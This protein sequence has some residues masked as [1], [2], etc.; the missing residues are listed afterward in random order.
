M[1]DDGGAE[2]G[3]AG[4]RLLE[5][6][7]NL[8]NWNFDINTPDAKDFYKNTLLHYSALVGIVVS[9]YNE[10]GDIYIQWSPS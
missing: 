4:T 9:T 8:A 6:I 5:M 10:G 7:N 1:I 3:E 2:G